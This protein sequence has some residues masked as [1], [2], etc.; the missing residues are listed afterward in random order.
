MHCVPVAQSCAITQ[1]ADVARHASA[2]T[3]WQR[4]NPTWCARRH[5]NATRTT[6]AVQ[7]APSRNADTA[8]H[9][10]RHGNTS[11]AQ[12]QRHEQTKHGYRGR[13]NKKIANHARSSASC[14]HATHQSIAASHARPTRTAA[15]GR[16]PQAQPVT[17]P[18][19][20]NNNL[21]IKINVCSHEWLM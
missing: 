6:R 5:R 20:A 7:C 10:R 18:T 16:T 15:Q 21:R 9:N 3:T 11:R 12:K 17:L 4:W 14:R 1:L 19:L 13:A 2:A 8:T